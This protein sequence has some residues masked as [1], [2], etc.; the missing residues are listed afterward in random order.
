MEMG[1][2]DL[3]EK[4]WTSGRGLSKGCRLHTWQ[5]HAGERGTGQHV[6]WGG[7]SRAW[8]PSVDVSVTPKLKLGNPKVSREFL[9]PKTSPLA[10]DH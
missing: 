8:A 2:Q 1:S 10:L 4:G 9:L 5:E 3:R 6:A 7:G